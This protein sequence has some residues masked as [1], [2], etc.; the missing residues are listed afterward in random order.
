MPVSPIPGF[1]AWKSVKKLL[2]IRAKSELVRKSWSSG[3]GMVGG[4]MVKLAALD[5]I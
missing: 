3:G 5:P 2:S 1:S 4:A